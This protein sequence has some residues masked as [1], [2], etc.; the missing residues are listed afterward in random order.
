M[1]AT[2]VSGFASECETVTV[3]PV[4]YVSTFDGFMNGEIGFSF[5]KSNRTSCLLLLVK[6]KVKS[7]SKHW[8]FF[9]RLVP[10]SQLKR[11]VR[12][13]KLLL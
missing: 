8:D 5:D 9:Y 4:G 13:R 1:Q 3:P 11:I 7:C 12:V 6:S 10:V 2:E